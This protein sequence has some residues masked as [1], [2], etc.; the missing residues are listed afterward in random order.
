MA[1]NQSP[2]S[3]A[4][5][6]QIVRERPLSIP[7]PFEKAIEGLLRVKSQPKLSAKKKPGRKK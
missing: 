4:A 3:M 1:V 2:K 5:K 7:M 6:N